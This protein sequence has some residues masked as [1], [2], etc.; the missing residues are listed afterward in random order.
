MALFAGCAPGRAPERPAAVPLNTS[1]IERI[2]LAG[3]WKYLPYNGEGEMGSP[4][5]DDRGWPSMSLPSNWF[6]L[7]KKE[8]PRK[9]TALLQAFGD[10]APGE[11]WPVDPEKGLDFAGTIWFRRSV[12]WNGDLS[13][14][15]VLD[16]DMV[17]YYA[18]VFV[19]GV[20][21]GRH[22]GYF[23]KWSVDAT[24]A[25]RRGSNVLAV[26][27]SAPTLTFDMSQQYPVSWP[28]MQNQVKGI[29]AY[30]DTRPGA[31]SW[32]GQERSTGGILRG[33]G[34]RSSTG[35]DLSE[36]LV[37]PREVSA[38][39][40]VLVVEATAQNWTDKPQN[41][42]VL[43][44]IHPSNFTDDG[45]GAALP[46]VKIT[47]EAKPGKSRARA[48]VTVD[49]PHLW[50]PAG[51]GKPDLYEIEARLMT[52]QSTLDQKKARFGIRSIARDDGWVFRVNGKRVYPRGTNYI[53]TQW[54]SQADR[55]YYERDLR[56]LLDAHMNAIRVHAHLERPEFYEVA[57]ELGVMVW[58]DFPLQWGYT[59]MPSFRE[60]ALRQAE[61]MIRRYGDYPS[62]ILWCM[63]N[64]SPHAMTW[65][66]KKTADQ[67]LALD[68][69]LT[70]AAR[71]LDPSRI[72]HR[73]SGTGDG[74]YYFGWYDG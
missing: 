53:S 23:Q 44:T 56:L 5:I 24:R 34:M 55:A 27:V 37:T 3:D 36:V 32:R 52:G 12:D 42:D 38:D 1:P 30:H 73:D 45:K 13:R 74:H 25:M 67:N 63:H 49:H 10:N 64:E 31:T 54:L 14:P 6:L 43:G 18:E 20:S 48:E 11:L 50:W 21:V 40:A 57:D 22:E 9:A 58:Q 46:T 68:D 33:I 28:K 16:L 2:D 65:M 59:D 15:V 17:D 71:A 66:K 29:F 4:A 35:V 62:I 26:K 72:V 8:Y 39:K 19:N 51:Y 47:F 60:E 7:G 69:A 61:D 70:A 41:V